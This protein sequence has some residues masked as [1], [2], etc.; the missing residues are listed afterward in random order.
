MR[1]IIIFIKLPLFIQVIY[2]KVF[3]LLPLCQCSVKLLHFK[4]LLILYKLQPYKEKP[5]TSLKSEDYVKIVAS[6]I[7]KTASIPLLIR[8]R[9]LAQALAARVLLHQRG[10]SCILSI[11]ATI[12]EKGMIAHAWLKCGDIIVTGQEEKDKYTEIASY[13]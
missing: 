8:P 5:I 13:C 11:G 6:A 3:I 9:C 4:H 7:R 2:I 10:Q 12:E 1:R